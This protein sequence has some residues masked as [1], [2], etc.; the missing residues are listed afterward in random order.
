[1]GVIRVGLTEIMTFQQRLE[2]GREGPWG[3]LGSRQGEWQGSGSC[4]IY[5]RRD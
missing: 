4:Q 2:G 1:M 3:Y 5:L